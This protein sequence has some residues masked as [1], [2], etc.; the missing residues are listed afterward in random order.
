[1]YDE[2]ESR[3]HEIALELAALERQLRGMTPAAPRIDRDCLMFAA[4]QAAALAEASQDGR[5]MYDRSGRPLYFAGSSRAGRRFWPAATCTMTAAT[6]LLATMLVWQSRRQPIAQ[7][8]VPMQPAVVASSSSHDFVMDR[9]ARLATHNT[10]PSIPSV[11]S[12]YLGVR[13]VALTR[14]IGALSS[15]LQS[16]NGDDE[17][18]SS[19][20]AEPNT[21]RGLLNEFLPATHPSKS[22]RS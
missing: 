1:M 22:S 9:P 12:G 7:Q 8:S 3:E 2:Q 19:N 17:M 13:Y 21:R 5:A 20:H 6:L 16:P 15:E 4:G 11:N 14:G 18:P 10:W